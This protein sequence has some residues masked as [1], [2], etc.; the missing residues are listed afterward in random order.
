MK[1]PKFLAP[2]LIATTVAAAVAAL[3]WYFGSDRRLPK[4]LGSAAA[5]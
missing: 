5:A 3:A 1:T 4:P 2:T